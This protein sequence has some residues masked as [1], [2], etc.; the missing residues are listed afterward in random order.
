MG[1][2]YQR[3]LVWQ[4]AHPTLP[5]MMECVAIRRPDGRVELLIERERV[6]EAFGVFADAATAVR[7]AF[8]FEAEMIRRG[9]QK[10]V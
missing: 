4:L 5:T 1:P 9:W 2:E 7:T 6:Q 8:R 10:I 3:T